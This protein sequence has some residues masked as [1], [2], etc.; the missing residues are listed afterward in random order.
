MMDEGINIT[1]CLSPYY[2]PDPY[3][4]TDAV[5]LLLVG[6]YGLVCC[7]LGNTCLCIV[8]RRWPQILVIDVP[9]VVMLSV[10]SFAHLCFIYLS[11]SFIPEMTEQILQVSCTL[12]TYWGQYLVGLG[13][14][15]ALLFVR[16]YSLLT[17]LT[18]PSRATG[19]KSKKLILR[20]NVFLLFLLPLYCL[21]LSAGISDEIYYDDEYGVC[22]APFR[23][24][25]SLVILLVI[26]TVALT[27]ISITLSYYEIRP[28][29]SSA[30]LE[31]VRL[32]SFF[33]LIG[34][35]VHFA[36][37]VPHYWGR[38]AFI[39]IA[40]FMHMVIYAI[41]VIPSFLAYYRCP[42]RRAS[43]AAGTAWYERSINTD[44]D[45]STIDNVRQLQ[46]P[47]SAYQLQ[48]MLRQRG[49]MMHKD[50]FIS[51]ENLRTTFF[52]YCVENMKDVHVRYRTGKW[53]TLTTTAKAGEPTV[54]TLNNFYNALVSILNERTRPY[55]AD[56][57][58]NAMAQC[59]GI[60]SRVTNLRNTYLERDAC[61]YISFDNDVLNRM[62]Y[63][64]NGDTIDTLDIRVVEQ[65]RDSILDFLIEENMYGYNTFFVHYITDL[66]EK[67]KDDYG[68][69]CV[70]TEEYDD[71]N[72][73]KDLV[74]AFES[75]VDSI[76]DGELEF[77]YEDDYSAPVVSE[78]Y[79]DVK[80]IEKSEPRLN[81]LE[82][83]SDGS[84][85][86]PSPWLATVAFWY[87]SRESVRGCISLCMSHTREVQDPE[88]EGESL[89]K[90]A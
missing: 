31:I 51:L 19:E 5:A 3:G 9:L 45:I 60:K 46:I 24:K 13:T 52:I 82:M 4:A 49:L 16:C 80:K 89:M 54:M 59:G 53:H 79:T 29:V 44:G 15:L 64:F 90:S 72:E 12:T 88:I 18:A 67:Y 68:F 36:H 33:V 10:S 32:V 38:L 62:K 84:A 86:Y 83:L 7:V 30:V 81:G 57:S 76:D 37:I 28:Q 42:R 43:E 85:I 1:I 73:I 25:L 56:A 65:L 27:V 23:Y 41:L 22:V 70:G 63:G 11:M 55:S 71:E 75:S 47:E 6:V 61:N 8:A 39:S 50:Y 69:D 21:C 2:P 58:L 26:Y 87:D 34:S 20:G 48:R 77:E 74:D 40:F 66:I 78:R 35:I 17:G 14:V